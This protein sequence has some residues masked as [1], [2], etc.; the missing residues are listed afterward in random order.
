MLVE[1]AILSVV[2]SAILG[3]ALHIVPNTNNEQPVR[4]SRISS[5]IITVTFI[6]P[7][8]FAVVM[9]ISVFVSYG[10]MSGIIVAFMLTTLCL[11]CCCCGEQLNRGA[12][13]ATDPDFDAV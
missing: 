7:S 5:F 4:S 12:R 8:I 1:S 2:L 13:F 9:T 6:F 11:F 10:L 3:V